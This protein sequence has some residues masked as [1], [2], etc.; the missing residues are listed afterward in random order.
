MG[1]LGFQAWGSP[2]SCKARIHN[3]WGYPWYP[4]QLFDTPTVFDGGLMDAWSVSSVCH[5]KSHEMLASIYVLCNILW[6]HFAI[7]KVFISI[8]DWPWQIWQ[9]CPDHRACVAFRNMLLAIGIPVRLT[10][11]TDQTTCL[12]VSVGCIRINAPFRPVLQIDS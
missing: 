7:F 5:F 6:P 2:G 9:T 11:V 8:F 10:L 12:Y 1:P 3:N 4:W